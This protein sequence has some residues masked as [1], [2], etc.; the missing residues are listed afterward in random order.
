LFARTG[1][2]G[3]T[4][5]LL[6]QCLWAGTVFS[7]IRRARAA[8]LD[9]DA[10]LLLWMGGYVLLILVAATLGVVLEGPYGAIPFYLLIGTSLRFAHEILQSAEVPPRVFPWTMQDVGTAR[11]LA[12]LRDSRG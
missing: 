9:D 3:L 2:V 1:I 12:P 4:L 8:G 5:W 10:D 7:A 11:Q 6:A